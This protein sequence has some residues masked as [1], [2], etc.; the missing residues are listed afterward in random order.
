MIICKKNNY[1]LTNKNFSYKKIYNII[2][3]NIPKSIFIALDYKF[4]KNIEK[5]KIIEIFLIKNKQEIASIISVISIQN[6]KV[7]KKKIF[8]YFLLNPYKLLKYFTFLSTLSGR[9][10]IDS[11]LNKKNNYLHLLHLIIFNNN[12][13]K[14]SLKNKDKLLNYF[15]KKILNIYNANCFFLCYETDN[16][17]AHK[18]YKRNKFKIYDKSKNTIYTK[19]IFK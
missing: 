14:M 12:F 17:K 3:K 8:L 2:I 7:L 11:N 16:I 9:K 15:Y 10:S 18:Y 4:L 6:Y 13:K 19:K 1:F 5:E